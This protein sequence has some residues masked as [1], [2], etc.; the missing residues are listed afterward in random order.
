MTDTTALLDFIVHRA[1]VGIFVINREREIILWNQFMEINSECSAEHAT[2]KN[3][4]ELFP[5]LPR[6]WLERKIE[7]VF[8]LKNFSFTSWE[9]RPYLFK[10]IHNRPV[11]G[12]I[13]HM[14][15]DC[16]L[17][18][19]KDSAGEV[20]HVCFTLFDAT[21]TSIYQT[22]L[23]KVMAKLEIASNIDSLTNL[24][25]RRFVENALS[26]EFSRALRHKHSLSLILADIDH[27][28]QVNDKYGH[29]VGD[30]VLRIASK[31]LKEC[32]R[33]FDIVGRYG[34][35]E[36]IV[37]LP[38]TDIEGAKLFAERMRHT[39]ENDPIQ[40]GDESLSITI[41]L[42]IT[43][44]NKRIQVYEDLISEADKALYFSKAA[45]RNMATVFMCTEEN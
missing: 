12:G 39:I 1:H 25:N 16:T 37:L 20:T 35:E 3:L 18:P 23:K 34:G 41:S 7:S 27:F 17:M 5:E 45:G 24:Y 36:F 28:K 44:I 8:I 11:T 13:D 19:I 40:A 31:R 33:T 14:R 4:F 38:E 2:G 29:L 32:L 15:Q 10:F 9:Q 21:D 30:E 22:Q 43:E 6:K 26:K 42:G